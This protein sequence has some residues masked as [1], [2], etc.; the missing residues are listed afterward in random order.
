M[1]RSTATPVPMPALVP[2][3][4]LLF[5]RVSRP[6]KAVLEGEDAGVV[7]AAMP[8]ED[9][10]A[11]M[12]GILADVELDEEVDVPDLVLTTFP[13]PSMTMPRSSRQQLG[14]LSQQKLPSSH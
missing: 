1:S 11:L 13:F 10:D 2:I 14:S 5:P 3:D 8:M 9:V 4:M 6:S 7:D 12:G